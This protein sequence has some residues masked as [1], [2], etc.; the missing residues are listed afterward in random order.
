[1]PDACRGDC[2]QGPVRARSPDLILGNAVLAKPIP[3]PWFIAA[4]LQ[5][6]AHR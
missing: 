3:R 5:T 4:P 6:V 2:D 1:M